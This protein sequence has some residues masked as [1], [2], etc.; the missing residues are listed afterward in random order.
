MYTGSCYVYSMLFICLLIF[1]YYIS[2]IIIYGKLNTILDNA[3]VTKYTKKSVNSIVLIL[4]VTPLLLTF[5]FNP[6]TFY[7]LFLSYILMGLI[8]S[9]C[10]KIKREKNS[11]VYTE[12][13]PPKYSTH[14]H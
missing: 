10:I 9:C 8:T 12:I 14:S 6:I 3:N 13:T 7:F 2:M 1:G 5:I 4:T 11:Q